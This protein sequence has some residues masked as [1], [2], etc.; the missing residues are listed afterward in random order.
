M[1]LNSRRDGG[2][3]ADVLVGP[4]HRLDRSVA[5]RSDRGERRKPGRKETLRRFAL[6]LQQIGQAG[7][8]RVRGRHRE[9]EA[10]AIA[11]D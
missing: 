3:A 1:R 4:P 10:E 2:A 9:A 7:R 8:Q 11:A 6:Q 5:S